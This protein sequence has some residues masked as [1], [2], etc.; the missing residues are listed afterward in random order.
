MQVT[1]CV[2][3][4]GFDPLPSQEVQRKICESCDE[5]DK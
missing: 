1:M 2:F 3:L 4:I 5:N